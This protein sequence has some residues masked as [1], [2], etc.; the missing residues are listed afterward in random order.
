VARR[1]AKD[2]RQNLANANKA[3]GKARRLATKIIEFEDEDDSICSYDYHQLMSVPGATEKTI[4][5][6]G[7]FTQSFVIPAGS[8]FVY[9]ARVRYHDIGFAL[10]ERK[11]DGRIEDIEPMTKFRAE[12]RATI[13]GQLHASDK[14][15]TIMLVFD[16]SFSQFQAKR[17]VFWVACGEKVSLADDAL[18]AARTMEV[19]AAEEGPAE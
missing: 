1:A 3:V 2:G 9:K 19:Q 17:V 15:R 14:E 16:N 11:E 12:D 8:I 6:Y 4:N 13:Q 7:H 18:G 10:R 5:I